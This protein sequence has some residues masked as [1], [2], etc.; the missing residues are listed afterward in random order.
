[1]VVASRLAPRTRVRVRLATSEERAAR[2]NAD[3]PTIVNGYGEWLYADTGE[4]FP[5][6]RPRALR[7]IDAHLG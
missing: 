3:R 7:V 1:L 5:T 2:A 6:V 4:P